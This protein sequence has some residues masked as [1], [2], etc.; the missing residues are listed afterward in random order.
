MSIDI[1]EFRS[2]ESLLSA[3]DSEFKRTIEADTKI[4][5][6]HRQPEWFLEVQE[7][8]RIAHEKMYKEF[9]IMRNLYKNRKA[10]EKLLKEL[11]K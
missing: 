11:K 4:N 5:K 9:K 1:F 6:L 2:L 10:N 7:E 3:I 8:N